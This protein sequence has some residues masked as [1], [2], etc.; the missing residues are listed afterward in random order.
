MIDLSKEGRTSGGSFEVSMSMYQIYNG[1]LAD[2]LEHSNSTIKP[3]EITQGDDGSGKLVTVIKGLSSHPLKGVYDCQSLLQRAGKMLRIQCSECQD[4]DLHLRSHSAV[5][6]SLYKTN[7]GEKKLV[8]RT[9][10][11]ELAS[12]EQAV[13]KSKPKLNKSIA[14]NFNNLSVKLLNHSLGKMASPKDKL[15]RCMDMT[16]DLAA[17]VLFVCC[18][19]PM[20]GKLRHTLPALKFTSKIMECITS[21][22]GPGAE[23][24]EPDQEQEANPDRELTERESKAAEDEKEDTAKPHERLARANEEAMESTVRRSTVLEESSKEPVEP[25]RAK[26]QENDEDLQRSIEMKRK[27]LDSDQKEREFEDDLR[28]VREEMQQLEKQRVTTHIEAEQAL[29]SLVTEQQPVL[30]TMRPNSTSVQEASKFSDRARRLRDEIREEQQNRS[31]LLSRRK[32]DDNVQPCR[33]TER[34]DFPATTSRVRN[35]SRPVLHME[36]V[37]APPAGETSSSFSPPEKTHHS[38]VLS[39]DAENIVKKY[40]GKVAGSVLSS[41]PAEGDE[42]DEEESEDEVLAKQKPREQPKKPA[43]G[44]YEKKLG[45]IEKRSKSIAKTLKKVMAAEA[46]GEGNA[47][48]AVQQYEAL[49]AETKALYEKS[50]QGLAE[51]NAMLK[52][53]LNRTKDTRERDEHVA[54]KDATKKLARK[55]AE[56][57]EL[58]ERLA[59][60]EENAKKSAANME[61]TKTL[62]SNAMQKL[63]EISSKQEAAVRECEQKA[64]KELDQLRS[65][66]GELKGKMKEK[67]DTLAKLQSTHTADANELAELKY[68]LGAE[69]KATSDAQEELRHVQSKLEE[70]QAKYVDAEKKASKLA[71]KMVPP[72]AQYQ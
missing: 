48:N 16:M 18:A 55:E 10:F 1:K 59:I 67:N 35:I 71:K 51:K 36:T 68:K 60:F 25:V 44:E 56:I 69:G 12:S 53:E 24:A 20:P 33:R 58:R 38:L 28:R 22:L 4:N 15:S 37:R 70:V 54:E 39:Q 40:S 63:E 26:L 46:R 5:L 11:V 6:L 3:I 8:G 2:L 57:D 49:F 41:S 62:N 34:E 32:L 9:Q 27:K 50:L 45:S 66:V 19:S 7:R 23:A 61:E 13:E 47:A 72:L 30:S 21:K 43:A 64:Q 42:P 14:S 65:Q 17:P 29:K 31:E 52:D